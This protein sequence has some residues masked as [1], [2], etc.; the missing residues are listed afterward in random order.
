M[1]FAPTQ[2]MVRQIEPHPSRSSPQCRTCAHFDRSPAAGSGTGSGDVCDHPAQPVSLV[3]G[4]SRVQAAVAR[5][6]ARL[7]GLDSVQCGPEGALH[8]P[9]RAGLPGPGTPARWRHTMPPL[10]DGTVLLMMQA[11]TGVKLPLALPADSARQLLASLI[12]ALPRGR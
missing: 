9:R 8:S 2:V 3:H 7:N 6:P 4:R 5:M 12:T 1:D 11:D 10:P